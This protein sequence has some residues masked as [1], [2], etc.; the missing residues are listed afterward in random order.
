[1]LLAHATWI[2]AETPQRARDWWGATRSGRECGGTEPPESPVF[3][4]WQ[5]KGAQNLFLA[6]CSPHATLYGFFGFELFFFGGLW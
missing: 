3:F 5:K 4:A 1:L 2:E 6:P